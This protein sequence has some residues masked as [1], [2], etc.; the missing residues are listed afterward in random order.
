MIPKYRY[1]Y[2][3]PVVVPKYF[4]NKLELIT[5][6]NSSDE[7]DSVFGEFDL[8]NFFESSEFKTKSIN[9]NFLKTYGLSMNRKI[10]RVGKTLQIF[11]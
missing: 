4:W 9:F 3:Y 2:G 8:I 10:F 5:Q 11:T 6:D 1:K 7:I